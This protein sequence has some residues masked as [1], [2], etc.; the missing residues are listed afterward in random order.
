MTG[1]ALDKGVSLIPFEKALGF[2]Q[3]NAELAAK[4]V[5]AVADWTKDKLLDAAV[6]TTY[7][8]ARSRPCSMA[9]AS[10]FLSHHL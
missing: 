8:K 7:D 4:A 6:D 2:S 5:S 10:R 1:P 3:A 9:L